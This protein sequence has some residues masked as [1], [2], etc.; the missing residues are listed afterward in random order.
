MA[1][2]A[3]RFADVGFGHPRGV[4][5]SIGGRLM[6]QG[7]GATE[8]HLVELAALTP[9]DAVV[10]IGP[11]PGVGLH[12]AAVRARHVTGVDPSER[13]LAACRRRCAAQVE[14]GVVTLVHGDAERT[15]QADASADVVL[16]VNNVMLWPDWRRAF[17]E[18]HRIVRP[19]GRLLMSVHAKWLP[20]GLPALMV[21]VQDA[22]FS[23]V[24][25]WTWEP[26][27]RGASTAAQLRALR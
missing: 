18:L 12:A 14:Q 2:L 17:C 27:S 1:G 6:A 19:G 10:V 5:G 9:T 21:A 22:G 23:D 3:K 7:N 20:G 13:M 4:L 15:E 26:P 16:S 8:R 11:G 24:T 25:S